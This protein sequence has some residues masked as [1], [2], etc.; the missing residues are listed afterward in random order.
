MYVHEVLGIT[1][2]DTVMVIFTRFADVTV[3]AVLAGVT[4]YT[5]ALTLAVGL[6]VM[7]HVFGL[8]SSP[9]GSAGVTVHAVTADPAEQVM[10]GF[11]VVTSIFC[12]NVGARSW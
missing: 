7:S 9:A 10:T 8:R 4:V 2:S 5:V 6:P 12:L 3:P 11:A 1:S